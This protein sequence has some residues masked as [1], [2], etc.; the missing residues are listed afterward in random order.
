MSL[1]LHVV[2]SFF[3]HDYSS[4][5]IQ[6]AVSDDSRALCLLKMDLFGQN[7]ELVVSFCEHTAAAQASASDDVY[8]EC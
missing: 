8:V 4:Y 2:F 7:F 5:S 1:R 3:R 6:R